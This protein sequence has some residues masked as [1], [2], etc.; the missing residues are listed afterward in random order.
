M[1]LDQHGFVRAC[2]MNEAHVLGNVRNATLTEIWRGERAA[3]LRRAM[4]AHDLTLGCD[5][6]RWPIEAGRQDLA[7]SRWFTELPVRAAEPAWPAQL[8]L[9]ISNTCNLQCVMCNGEWSSSIRSQREGLAPLP[10]VYDDAFFDELRAFVPHLERVKFLGGEPFLAG[11]TL[12]VMDLLVEG[13]STARCHVTTNGTQWTPRVERLLEMLPVDISVSLD[14]TSAATY[15]GIRVGSSWATVRENLDRFRATA[16]R[17]GTTVSITMCLMRQNWHEFA[18]FCLLADE[19]DISCDVNTVTQPTA[20]SLYHLP[21]DELATVVD[22]LQA[23]DRELGDRLGWSRATWKGELERLR[24]HLADRRAGVPVRGIDVQAEQP[25]TVR[26]WEH[27][28]G[29]VPPAGPRPG[30]AERQLAAVGPDA[31]LVLLDHDDLIVGA[32]PEV[33]G[34]PSSALEGQPAARMMEIF[35]A[36]LSPIVAVE[37]GPGEEDDRTLA[38][39]LTDGRHIRVFTTPAFDDG[40]RTGTEVRLAWGDPS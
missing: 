11:E 32:D 6:C 16:R 24:T 28:E 31:D 29:S 14:A 37:H 2:C 1:Y 19:L 38:V 30:V 8:E 34:V 9:S 20:M 40:R 22:A 13:G 10:K 23:R 25:V 3:E 4:E 33:L 26:P 27:H 39:S 36:H 12:R 15:E 17:R 18:D 7:F 35:G 21:A 5:F